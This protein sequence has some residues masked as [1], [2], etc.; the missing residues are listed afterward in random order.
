MKHSYALRIKVS[1]PAL[2]WTHHPQRPSTSAPH[3]LALLLRCQ[4]K[5]STRKKQNKKRLKMQLR[6][7]LRQKVRWHR[8]PK[9][10]AMTK[11]H[12]RQRRRREKS[13]L[14][15]HLRQNPG[16][17]KKKSEKTGKK[18]DGGKE[19]RTLRKR[20]S[21]EPTVEQGENE[22]PTAIK[23]APWLAIVRTGNEPAPGTATAGYHQRSS[24]RFSAT[25]NCWSALRRRRLDDA[26]E[27]ASPAWRRRV[28]KDALC[29]PCR[30][31]RS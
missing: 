9:R 24:D 4:T 16:A 2:S 1:S 3:L 14:R 17:G 31:A 20:S 25:R 12:T 11:N 27:S 18:S 21:A 26:S 23:P 15:N 22:T 5:A 29:L 30:G 8:S 6:S 19:T 13:R 7:N 28:Q 10:L